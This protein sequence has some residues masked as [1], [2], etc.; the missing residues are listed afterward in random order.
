VGAT[1]KSLDAPLLD[2][3]A[4]LAALNNVG[5]DSSTAGTSLNRMFLGM[6]TQGKKASKLMEELGLSFTD[7]AGAMVPMEEA[8][9]RLTAE[10]AEMTK[11]ERAEALK[12]LFGV[13]GMRAA[14][15][16]IDLGTGGWGTLREQIDQTG[17][18]AEMSEARMAGFYGAL[19]TARGAIE[20]LGISLGEK[21]LPILTG[22]ITDFTEFMESP[23]GKAWATALADT[24]E[25]LATGLQTWIEETL[26]PAFESVV[27]WFQDPENQASIK[28]WGDN[29]T[30]LAGAIETAMGAA[31]SAITAVVDAWNAMPS[32]M[33]TAMKEAGSFAIAPGAYVGSR[34]DAP[35]DGPGSGRGGDPTPRR[36]DSVTNITVN[37]T[38]K[39]KAEDSVALALRIDRTVN[40]GR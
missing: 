14:I 39:T 31:A 18:A 32:W 22:W 5:L 37:Q 40:T 4:A 23:E 20:T 6:A 25:G 9:R 19:E 17:L 30:L 34:F 38:V 24:I 7:S 21:L 11:P 27:A 33:R 2:T 36:P 1:A 13:E 15:A 29:F 10:T 12:T 26:I 8:I 35:T 3:V 28:A 16:L